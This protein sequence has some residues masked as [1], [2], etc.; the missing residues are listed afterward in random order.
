MNW[1]ALDVPLVFAICCIFFMGTKLFLSD[2][3]FLFYLV[4]KFKDPTCDSFR[5]N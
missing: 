4:V 2:T 3:V 5:V 1:F